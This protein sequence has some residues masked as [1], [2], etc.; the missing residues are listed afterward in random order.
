MNEHAQHWKGKN[1]SK[2]RKNESFWY[3]FFNNKI[4]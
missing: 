4:K 3:F 1:V 2:K